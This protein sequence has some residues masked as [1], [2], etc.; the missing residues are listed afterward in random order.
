MSYSRSQLLA[1]VE[2]GQDCANPGN[3]GVFV[4][5]FGKVESVMCNTIDRNL[6]VCDSKQVSLCAG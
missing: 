5:E 2:W 3:A 6:F 4:S 1:S